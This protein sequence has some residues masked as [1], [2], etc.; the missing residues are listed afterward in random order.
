[1]KKLK[2]LAGMVRQEILRV[3]TG[4]RI[5][6]SYILFVIMC[7]VICEQYGATGAKESFDYIADLSNTG[8]LLVVLASFPFACS[9]CDDWLG[10]YYRPAVARG[11]S[12]N[13]ILAKIIMCVFV[14]FLVSFAGMF[15]FVC[16]RIITQ[17]YNFQN[18]YHMLYEQLAINGHVILYFL[19]ASFIYALVTPIYAIW[20]MAISAL[21]PNRFVAVMTPLFICICIQSITDKLPRFL[22]THRISSTSN[23]FDLPIESSLI[24]PSLILTI[25]V[26]WGYILIGA[27]IFAKAAGGRIHNEI[28]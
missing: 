4:W 5:Y 18:Y 8:F 27:V 15:T 21:L 10:C 1:M 3:I 14:S 19:L 11:G 26:T 9:F 24:V 12:T 20:G 16:I 22:R 23:L 25:M 17:G 28:V 2:L 13:Y 7:I 6:V